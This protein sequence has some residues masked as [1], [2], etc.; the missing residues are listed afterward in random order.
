M[1]NAKSPEHPQVAFFLPDLRG[2]GAEKV[3][4]TL[5]N[6]LARQGLK[7]D[8]VLV[9][10]IGVN[11]KNLSGDVKVVNLEAVNT[12]LSLLKLIRYFQQ[13]R[14]AVFISSLDLTNIIAIIARRLSG[15]KTRLLIRIENMVSSQKRSF[16][17]KGVEKFLLSHLYPWADGVITVSRS[18]ADDITVYAGISTSKIH[19]I[20]NPVITP[21]LLLRS[22]DVAI[23][24]WFQNDS[25]PV[26]LGTGRLTEQKDF[27]TLIAAFA[28]LRRELEV[29]LIILG[30]GD[31]RLELESLAQKLGVDRDVD[32]HGYVE[33][34]YP[35]MKQADVF[36]LSSAWEGLPTVLIE[37]LACGCSVVS[38]D[39]P[40]GIREILSDGVYGEL[41]PVASSLAMAEAIR[42]VILNEKRVVDPS[43]LDQFS[44]EQVVEQNMR[45]LMLP[46]K[47]SG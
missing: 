7:V 12:Y 1:K 6:E 9:K 33:N 42:K 28:I 16:G 47:I 20:Y 15:L 13:R 11:I 4:T 44:L 10:A 36:V 17:K 31:E 8:F 2:G 25:I 18:V 5:A 46:I 22:K 26:I 30:E 32:L 43:W 39:C 23:H 40:G 41:V 35:Y 3:L 34:P 45:V 24:P 38:T 27:K 19:T 29:R 14:P 37:A 21:E